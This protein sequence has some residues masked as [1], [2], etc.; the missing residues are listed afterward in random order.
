MI[1]LLI[2]II[3]PETDLL[4]FHIQIQLIYQQQKIIGRSRPTCSTKVS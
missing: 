1:T 3:D 2:K 4:K